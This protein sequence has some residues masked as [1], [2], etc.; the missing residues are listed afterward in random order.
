MKD[1]IHIPELAKDLIEQ[2]AFEARKSEYI[3]A[4]SGVSARLPISA[5]ENLISSAE[6]RLLLG[7]DS[8]TTIRISDF[9]GVI[10]AITGKIELVYEG[11]QEGPA[12]VARYLFGKAIRNQFANY[13]PDPEKFKKKPD[14]SPY[15]RISEWF[16]KGNKVDILNDLTNS[17][18]DQVLKGVPNLE[19]LVDTYQPGLKKEEK[20]LFMEFALHALTEFSVLSK[21]LLERGSQFQDLLSSMFSSTEED[22]DDV[23]DISTAGYYR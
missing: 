13:F 12:K 22:D 5:Y 15:Q 21:H 18:Y 4:K 7:N 11:E 19:K 3:D 10:P 16:R 14:D 20:L 17:E 6:R 23:D 1:C 2:I 9:D 8:K